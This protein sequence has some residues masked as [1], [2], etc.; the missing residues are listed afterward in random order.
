MAKATAKLVKVVKADQTVHF[1][2]L[3]AKAQV[4][5]QSNLLPEHLKWQISEVDPSAAKNQPWKDKGHVTGPAAAV[6]KEKDE[7]IARLRELLKSKGTTAKAPNPDEKLGQTDPNPPAIE[8][9]QTV[10]SDQAIAKIG[11]LST[12]AEINA[13]VDG[14]SRVNVVKAATA[15]IEGLTA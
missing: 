10:K 1:V 8:K 9:S 15:K 5:A 12:E 6:V 2:P 13:Y 7:E 4:M 14:E 3:S 11:T